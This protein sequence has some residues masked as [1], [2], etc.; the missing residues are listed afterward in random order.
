MMNNTNTNTNEPVSVEKSITRRPSTRTSGYKTH[1]ESTGKEIIKRPITCHRLKKNEQ[2]TIT[3]KLSNLDIS[4]NNFVGFGGWFYV[5]AADDITYKTTN[6]G[7]NTRNIQIANN[8]W[9][10]FGSLYVKDDVDDLKI[11]DP[12][13]TF[14]ANEDLDIGFYELN[15]G[16]VQHDFLTDVLKED[17]K[18]LDNIHIYAPE[19]NFFEQEGEVSIVHPSPLLTHRE[20]LIWLKRCNRCARF[21]PV[22]F[23]NDSHPLS[24]SR[25]ARF[26]QHVDFETGDRVEA[27]KGFQLECRFCKKFAVNL[28]LNSQRTVDQLKEDGARR[29]GFEALLEQL[30]GESTQLTY[31]VKNNGRELA[32]FIWERFDCKCFNCGTELPTAK[33]MHLDH[34][35]PLSLLWPLDDTATCLCENCNSQKS[36]KT[37][38]EFYSN[39]KLSELSEITGISLDELQSSII[40]TEAVE[41]IIADLDWLIKD[42]CVEQNLNQFRDGKNTAELFLSAL[43]RVF[44]QTKYGIDYDLIKIYSEHYDSL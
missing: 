40:N 17:P 29:R 18:Q 19:A 26:K 43:Q 21:L 35:R 38:A 3:F 23:P 15:C 12:T 39:K 8:E 10:A 1:E 36:N 25:H 28:P 41:A 16:I 30:Y 32:T 31:R 7:N 4:P 13:I 11:I 33:D 6:F 14:T 9:S 44:N 5:S 34:T 2:I 22:N 37:P 42:F 20:A 27:S 24:F